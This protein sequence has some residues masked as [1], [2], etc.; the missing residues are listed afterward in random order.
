MA[1]T[2]KSPVVVGVDGSISATQ[3][4]RWAALEAHRRGAPLVLVHV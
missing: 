1:D 2:T 4:V 3:A